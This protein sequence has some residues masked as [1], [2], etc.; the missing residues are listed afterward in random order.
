M[1]KIYLIALS[2]LI[3]LSAI[4]GQSS[5][6]RTVQT[7]VADVLAQMPV[8]NQQDYNKQL[9]DLVSTGEEGILILVNMI[10]APGQGSNAQVDYALSGLSHYVMESGKESARLTTAK[11]YI[12]A[13][14]QVNERE[15]K[16]FI[17]RQL[18]IVGKDESVDA[19][20]RY[21]N[22]EDYSGPASRALASIGTEKATQAL[23]ASLL[24][25]MGTSKTQ[26]DAIL[27]IGEAKLPVAEDLIKGYINA[28][29]EN[30]RKDA[31]YTLSRI[32]S[33]A[34]LNDLATAAEKAGFTMEKTGANEAYIMLLKRMVE[35]GDTKEAEKA[36]NDLLKKATKANQVH[37]RSA[38]LQILLSIQKEKGLKLVQTALKDNSK[39]YRNAALDYISCYANKDMYVDLVKT[40]D[41]AKPEVK[42]DLLNW[43]G[44]ESKNPEKNTILKNLDIRFDLPAKQLFLNQLNSNDY[45][46]KEAAV[47]MLVKIGDPSVIPNLTALLTSSDVQSVQLAKAALASFK[48]DIAPAVAKVIPQAP[49]AGKIAGA[50]LLAA[51]KASANIN[52]VLELTKSGSPEVKAAAYTALKDVVAEKDFTLLCGMLE[53]ADASTIAPLQQAVISAIASQPKQE[54]VSTISRR[55]LQAGE[56]KKHLYYTALA[57]TNDSQAL[58]T[59]VAGF[60]Q[61]SGSAKDAAFEAILGWKGVEVADEL[62][63]I[64]KDKSASAYYDKAFAG[65]VKL[66]SAS[67]LSGEN[68]LIRL[69]KAMEVAK[70]DDQK[71]T[72]LR[73]TGRTGTF[74]GLL[75]AGEFLDSK[76]VQQAAANA[77]MTIA[78]AHPEYA[79]TNVRELLNKASKVLDNPDAGY[80]REAIKKHLNEMP[81]GEGF[82][83]LFNGKDLSGWKGLVEN[84]IVRAKMKPAQLAKAQEKAD[85]IMR[86]DWKVEDGLLVFDGPSYDNLCTVKQ[87]GDFEMY[88]DWMLDPAGPEAD[89]GIYLRGTP[90]V[91]MWDTARVRVGAQ[92]GSGGL[93]NNQVHESKPL[94]VADNKLGEWNTM[95]IKMIG[96]RVTVYLNGELV[97]DKVILENFW[98]RK[99]PIFPVEQLELQAHGSKVYYR[100][101]YVKELER[102]EPFK[103]STEEV[104]E[105]Y[106]VLFDG[107][108]MFEWTGNI[109]DYTLA[110]DGSITLMPNQGSGGNL[111]TKKEYGNFVFRFE[112]MLTPAANNGLGI[113][114]PMEGDAAYVGMELQILDNEHP[115][116]KDLKEHQYH[117]S[118]YGVIPA[119]RGYL[120]PLGEWNYQE[121]VA[122]GDN[123]KIT[124]NGEVILDGNIREAAKNGTRDGQNHPGLFNKKGHIGFLGHGS[125]VK[126]RNI[127]IKEL[128]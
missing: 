91:Q 66:A 40:M 27:A 99:Q 37:T 97:T 104:K 46:V 9:G 111:Y 105:G 65:Y 108:N 90:Q 55:M 31:L 73:H 89:A 1:K 103:L 22:M 102:P 48:G 119:K 107:T 120:K 41:K 109:T 25:R 82:V 77:V 42:V 67:T 58:N 13:L 59:I 30:F 94:K 51:R 83:S 23:Q 32:G 95:Y 56:S 122:N 60:K 74:L 127:R 117:G 79:G 49:D 16:A 24:R 62:Y 8:N 113:R 98:D 68:R 100:N 34:S 61:G 69:R 126:F 96:D 78:L 15:T 125:E 44:R 93:Y 11:A 19:L 4:M 87:Y 81:A 36:A 43:I 92:V 70:T 28:E 124:L 5:A 54:Q 29:D 72:I 10:H 2:W 20:A 84:P 26:R 52:T 101:I 3:C 18:Q 116:Y 53:T 63:A 45:A 33:K 14:E 121:V 50:E 12:K 7:V 115:V 38:A 110:E 64:C 114:T 57:A 21:L 76:P 35:Q 80:Q 47:W 85:E 123:I 86:R 88:V 112:F 17:I 39:E 75:Y 106:K 71:N 6:N 118:V 128:K